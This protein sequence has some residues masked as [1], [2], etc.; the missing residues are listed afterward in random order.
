MIWDIDKL[1]LDTC[2]AHVGYDGPRDPTAETLRAVQRAHVRHALPV[3]CSHGGEAGLDHQVV[4][5][6]PYRGGLRQG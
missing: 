4:H 1:V 6:V 3:S 2:L 5:G